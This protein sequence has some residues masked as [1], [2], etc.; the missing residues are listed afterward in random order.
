MNISFPKAGFMKTGFCLVALIGL[1]ACTTPLRQDAATD[2]KSLILAAIEVN[3][4]YTD[5]FLST[6]PG[7][8][9]DMSLRIWGHTSAVGAVSQKA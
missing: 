6:T 8:I 1:A 5:T 7:N 4:D 2:G 3:K 9:Y